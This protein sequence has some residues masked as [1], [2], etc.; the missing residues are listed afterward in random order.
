VTL[1]I[2]GH[3]NRFFTYLLTHYTS[4][5]PGAMERRKLVYCCSD[6]NNYEKFRSHSLQ[7]LHYRDAHQ[8]LFKKNVNFYRKTTLKS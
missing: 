1:I 8:V 3:I 6:E 5:N 2:V 7:Q 4:L